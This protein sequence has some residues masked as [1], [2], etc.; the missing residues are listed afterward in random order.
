MTYHDY[1]KN[2]KLNNFMVKITQILLLITIIILWQFLAGKNYINSF[3]T[4]SP[5]NILIT[6]TNTNT[7]I[8]KNAII[9][10]FFFINTLLYYL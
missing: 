1:L 6:P 2:I 10:L 5:K 8:T 3:I 4:S 9:P 7:T